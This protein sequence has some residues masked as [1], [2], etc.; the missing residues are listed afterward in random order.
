MKY[1]ELK[2]I[3]KANPKAAK[4]ALL[5][6]M[7]IALT[8]AAVLVVLAP[9]MQKNTL[10]V[11]L[12]FGFLSFF[13]IYSTMMVEIKLLKLLGKNEEDDKGELNNV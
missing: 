2:K 13:T 6:S 3:E 12:V 9:I 7:I 8:I 5:K 4:K 11:S 1:E 10:F